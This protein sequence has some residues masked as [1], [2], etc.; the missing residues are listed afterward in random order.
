MILASFVG[1]HAVEI[2]HFSDGTSTDTQTDLNTD[3]DIDTDTLGWV[4]QSDMPYASGALTSALLSD[5]L[6]VMGGASNYDG[7][8]RYR[9]HY[10]YNA[11]TQIWSDSP[12]DVPDGD[13]EGAQ[14][15]AYHDKIYLAG[16]YP[17]GNFRFRVY[18]RATNSWQSLTDIP[19]PYRYGFVSAVVGDFFYVIGG[20]DG[21]DTNAPVHKYNLLEGTWS[22]CANIPQNFGHG[23]LAGAA[24]DK[25]IYVLNGDPEGGAT[26]LQIFDT[27]NDSWS[28][29]K[30]IG[31]HYEAAAA[32]AYNGKVYFFGG[33][34][35]AWRGENPT[36]N[37]Q[38]IYDVGTNTWSTGESMPSARSSA[39]AQLI[40]NGFHVLGGLDDVGNGTA[41]HEVFYF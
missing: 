40:D 25:K 1:C 7:F 28:Y 6:H 14:A 23:S 39:T 13:M 34:E 15:Q 5:G 19:A 36:H 27:V 20:R 11:T 37:T 9:K 30:G 12:A 26:I 38:N 29:G 41:A 33:I 22:A 24:W 31:A 17:A 35:D 21:G 18:D 16:G 3:T 4:I 2:I 10:V 32:V 8:V